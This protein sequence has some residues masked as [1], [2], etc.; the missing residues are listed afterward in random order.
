MPVPTD[1]YMKARSSRYSQPNRF[2]LQ[3]SHMPTPTMI[4]GIAVIAALATRSTTGI[5]TGRTSPV[6]GRSSGGSTRVALVGIGAVRSSMTG[7]LGSYRKPPGPRVQQVRA[8]ITSPP[9][10][11]LAGRALR[12]A[13]R[14]AYGHHDRARQRHPAQRG[15]ARHHDEPRADQRTR[16][17]HRDQYS[18]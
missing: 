17:G 4:G 9:A 8:I 3:P 11:V 1:T 2:P 15:A 12:A 18:K 16:Y 7:S 13:D 14:H 6:S 5:D 10:G